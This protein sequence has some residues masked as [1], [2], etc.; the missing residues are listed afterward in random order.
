MFLGYPRSGHTLIRSL[1]DAHPNAIIANEFDVLVYVLLGFS[2]NQLFYLLLRRSKTRALKDQSYR[3]PSQWQGAFRELKVI[4]DK[5]AGATTFLLNRR[6]ELLQRLREMVGV[7]VKF[8][9]A[10]RNPY[11]NIS[12]IYLR[13]LKDGKASLERAVMDYFALVQT[14]AKLKSQI[15][16]EDIFDIRHEVLVEDPIG[17]LRS[18]CKFLG[19]EPSE[20]YLRDCAST[21]YKSPHKTRLLTPWTPE[22]IS[23]VQSQMQEFDF[24]FGYSFET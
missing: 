16:P 3:V 9:H 8:I 17:Q 1:I 11:D 20:D 14:N 10:I 5:K 23:S 21:V 7:P 4:G 18:L 22:M 24:L 2:K 6:P 15:G 19:L 12:S 13:H